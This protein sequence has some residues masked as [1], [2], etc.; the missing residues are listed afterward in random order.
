[1]DLIIRLWFAV[2]TLYMMGILLR[3]VGPWLE[4]NLDYGR[5][6]WVGAAV[7][8]LVRWLRRALPPLGP[9][10]YAPIAALLLVWVTR[11]IVFRIL[12]SLG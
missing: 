8:P 7:D 1:M 6:R 12:V 11:E 3:W 10:D 5:L 4:V 9:V 2:A